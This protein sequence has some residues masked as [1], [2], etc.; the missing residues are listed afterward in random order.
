MNSEESILFSVIIPTYNRAEIIGKAIESILSQTYNYWELI[1]VDDGSTDNTSEIIN[2]Y[3]DTRIKYFYKKNEERSIARNYGIAKAK[4]DYISFL[5]DDD[6]YLPQFLE[7][8]HSKIIEKNV[9]VAMIMCNE[10]TEDEKGIRELNYIP[11][12]LLDNP[13]RLLWEIQTSIRPFV[14]H[15]EILKTELFKEDC[16]FGQDFHLAIRIV[17]KFPYYY[18]PNALSVNKIHEIQGTQTKFKINYRKNAHFSIGCIDDL[19]KKYKYKLFNSIPQN[20]IYDLHN[21]KVYAF[22]SAAMKQHDFKFWW[23]LIK[24]ISLKGSIGKTCYYLISLFCRMPYY[25]IR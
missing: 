9:P 21:H 7:E 10:Y 5:D 11:K 22:A 3:N 4:G 1:I 17:L 14:I 19:I 15:K 12:K 25:L 2:S 8:F 18:I 23:Y 16:P 6:Y 13:V 20:K 24:R